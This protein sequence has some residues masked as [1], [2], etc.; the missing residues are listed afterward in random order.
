[1]SYLFETHYHTPQTSYCGHI[2]PSE[3]LP[4]YKEAGY[5]GVVVTDHFYK[6]WFDDR[7][8]LP[9]EDK[10]ERWLEGY[11]AARE[12]AAALPDFTVILG[13]E[14]RFTDNINDHLVYGID[15]GLLKKY[16]EPYLLTPA[17]F[18]AFADQHGLFFAQAHPFRDVCS[19]RNPADLHGVEVFNGNGRWNS[20]NDT[21]EDFAKRNGLIRLSGSDFHEW[22]DLCMGGV[23]L[24]ER[25]AD[26]QALARLLFDGGVEE[27]VVTA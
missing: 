24:R 27:L 19:P 14:L 4:K 18:R 26:S 13:M 7:G 17:E 9:W 15:E 5:D 11:R 22:E 12:A 3:A 6:E 2:P 10:I 23:Y 1:M 25:P 16:P 21:A 8:D 20:H